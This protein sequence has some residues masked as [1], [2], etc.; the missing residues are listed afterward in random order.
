[1]AHYD[2]PEIKR[3]IQALTG[4]EPVRSSFTLNWRGIYSPE[5]ARDMRIVGLTNTDLQFMAAICVEQGAI[6][7]RIHQTTTMNSWWA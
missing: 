6:I 5:S 4:V 2:E 7:H 1:M 3:A